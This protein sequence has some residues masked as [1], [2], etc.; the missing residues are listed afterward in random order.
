MRQKWTKVVVAI[1]LGVITS[2]PAMAKGREVLRLREGW[3]FTREDSP[4][5]KEVGY[6]ASKWQSVVVPHDWA[7]YGPFDPEIDKQFLAISQDGQKTPIYHTA[8]TGGLPHVGVGWY[9]NSFLLPKDYKCGDRVEIKFDG[10]MSNARVYINGKEAIYWPY[11]YSSFYVDITELIDT[12]KSQQ[13]VAVRLE[14]P[15][16][17]SRWYPGAGLYRNVWVTFASG[18]KVAEWGHQITTPKV[19]NEWAQVNIKTTIEN[20]LGVAPEQITLRTAILDGTTEVAVAE[21][22]GSE[23]FDQVLEQNIRLNQPK[24]WDLKQPNLYTARTEVSVDGKVVD[25]YSTTFGVRTIELIPDK[26]FFLNGRAVK[27]QGVCLH[28][29]LGPLGGATNKRGYERQ[30]KKMQEMGVNAIRTSHNMPAP[31]FIEAANELGIMVMAE[32]FDEWRIPKVENG[33]HLYFDEWANRDLTNLARQ[34]RNAPSIVMWS[35]GN[36]IYEQGSEGGNKYAYYLQ[37][38]F[39]REDPT[40]PV[41][42]GMNDPNGAVNNNFASVMDVAGFNYSNWLYGEAYKKLPQRLVMGAETT[43][44]VSSRGIYKFPVERRAMA[45]YDDQQCSSYDVEHCGWSNLPEDDFMNHEDFHYNIGEFVWT[46]IDYLGEPTPY[47]TEWPSHSSYFGAVDLAGIEKDRFYLYRSHW[48]K[49]EETLHILPHWNWQGRE[50]EVTPIFV[51]TNYPTAELFINGKSQGKCTKDLSINSE[52]SR[53]GI[54]RQPRYRLMWM[55]TTYEPGEVKVVAYDAEG[56]IAATKSMK[57]TGKPYAVRLTLENDQIRADGE[58]IAYVRVQIV[59]REGN[60]VPTATN[61]I[62]FKVTGAGDFHAAANG[63]ATCIV[64]FQSNKQL[65]F[66]GQLTAIVR[67]SKMPGTITLK[68]TARDLKSDT[69]K[70]NSI[71]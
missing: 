57:T 10:A 6:D 36:E 30:I 65:A 22:N 55:D 46:G 2:L 52:T 51:Y 50:G 29:D 24:L 34:F 13:S 9:R 68:A 60:V 5:F 62:T 15:D 42:V 33:Y 25:S 32:S 71:K 21:G 18:V 19:N 14:N 27:F 8:R 12:S 16:Q 40:R 49:R 47:Y 53:K 35:I 11:G 7:I 3:K 20:N 28:H 64:P 44:T 63:D 70:I 48:N 61:E 26:G 56:N 58:D 59:D 17:T 4:K 39:H 31:E 1:A 23:L 69:I 37:N 41:T 45:T 66:S 54:E 38:I 67:S 43:S